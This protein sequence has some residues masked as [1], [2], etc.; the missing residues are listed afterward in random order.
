MGQSTIRASLPPIYADLLSPIFDAPKV[1]ETRATCDACQMCDRGGSK[2]EANAVYFHPD[3]KCCTFFPSLPNYL[4]GGILSDPGSE[5]EEG[6]RRLRERIASRVGTLPQRVAPSKRW[7]VLYAAAMES[8]FGRSTL[9]KCPYL[10]GDGRCTIWR[11]REAV[12]F[13]FFCK[14]D[15]GA[16]GS[17]FWNELKA[18]LGIVEKNLCVWAAKQVWPEV[19]DFRHANSMTLS[20]EELEERPDDAKYAEAW[21]PWQGREEE[22]FLACHERVKAMTREQF[23]QVV[24]KTKQGREQLAKL[25][26]VIENLR[27]AKHVPARAALTKHL[28]VLPVDTGVVLTMP[29]NAHDSIKIENELYEVLKEFTHDRTVAETR[30]T[31]AKEQGIELDDELLS[32]FAMHE[33]LVGPPKGGTCDAAAP[34][35]LLGA[36]CAAPPKK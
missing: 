25:G 21:G 34:A 31:L 11:Y 7:S 6:R 10:A 20:L 1:E 9:L 18:Y 33:I 35:A 14:Y 13:S 30:E 29:Y 22:F 36:R 2:N 17:E 3:T 19:K 27:V 24:D 15:L 8:S 16:Y 23:A 12:C 32:M 5:I 28:R 4:V 26:L